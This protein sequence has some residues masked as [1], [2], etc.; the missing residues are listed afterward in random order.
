VIILDAT[1][2]ELE[3][4]VEEDLDEGLNTVQGYVVDAGPRGGKRKREA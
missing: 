4:E 1:E 3:F 2:V